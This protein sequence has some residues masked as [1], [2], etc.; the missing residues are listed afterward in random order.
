MDIRRLGL[1]ALLVALSLSLSLVFAEFIFRRF[2]PSL[3][4]NRP[5][6][7]LWQYDAELGWIGTPATS[8]TLNFPWGPVEVSTNSLGLRE[9]ELSPVDT[10]PTI[11]FIGDSFTWG[12]GLPKRER[13]T[14]LLQAKHPDVRIVNA[15]MSGYGTDQELLLL[16]RLLPRL[17]PKLVVA[18][19][20]E[21]DLEN[22]MS[23]EQYFYSKP[24]F[25]LVDDALMLRPGPVLGQTLWQRISQFLFVETA[26]GWTSHALV[27]SDYLRLPSSEE[28]RRRPDRIDSV[29]RVPGWWR[30][31]PDYQLTAALLKAM[32]IKAKLHGAEFAILIAPTNEDFSSA[33]RELSTEIGVP[34]VDP[35]AHPSWDPTAVRFKTDEHWNALGHRLVAEAIESVIPWETYS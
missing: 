3:S 16:T 7:A 30:H 28:S 33:L 6:R 12:F 21:N 9:E 34:C 2:L 1:R 22:N 14:D 8:A 29:K 18:V 26:L 4:P 20:F 35:A 32:K 10:R 27:T 5:D 13:F 31:R 24:C 19:P 17:S 23:C 15:G 25:E 11:L